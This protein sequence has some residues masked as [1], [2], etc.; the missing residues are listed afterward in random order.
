MRFPV[1][2]LT[3]EAVSRRM[4]FL[5]WQACAGPL[6]MGIF[7]NNPGAGEADVWKNVQTQADYPTK[8]SP[9]KPGQAYGDYVFGRMMKLS[10]SYDADTVTT[11]DGEPR[12]DYQSWCRKYPTYESLVNDAVKSLTAEPS[13]VA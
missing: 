2:P 10:V 5:A 11:P 4:F 13:T 8:L 9:N 3:G 7:Q 12:A 6:G 1:T